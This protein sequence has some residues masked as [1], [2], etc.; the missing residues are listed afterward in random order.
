MDREICD[1][2]FSLNDRENSSQL[3]LSQ[4]T[5]RPMRHKLA[6]ILSKHKIEDLLQLID[7]R[8]EDPVGDPAELVR[9]IF[10]GTKIFSKH[11]VFE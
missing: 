7:K 2:A 1:A 10:I 8:C 3:S 6:E 11:W 9:A 5:R 4:V